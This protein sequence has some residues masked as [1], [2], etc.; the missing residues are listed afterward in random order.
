MLKD[1]ECEHRDSDER[2][3]LLAL[4]DV[5]RSE[6]E[7]WIDLARVRREYREARVSPPNVQHYWWQRD[8]KAALLAGVTSLTSL[9]GETLSLPPLLLP[10]SAMKCVNCLRVYNSNSAA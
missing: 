5:P 4:G 3:Q 6:Y 8:E 9:C 7:G 1:P 2:E 10:S